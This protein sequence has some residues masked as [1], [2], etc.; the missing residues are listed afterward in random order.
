MQKLLLSLFVMSLFSCENNSQTN[1]KTDILIEENS[2]ISINE[3]KSL[4]EQ[5]WETFKKSVLDKNIQGIAAFASSD[6]IDSET[7]LTYLSD[8]EILKQLK[9]TS[10]NNLT[11]EIQGESNYLV[12]S[13]LLNEFDDDGNQYESGIYLYFIKSDTNLMLDYYLIAG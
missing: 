3:N 12:F 1:V 11:S 9:L 13:V 8:E 5:D 6:E 10:F 2:G 4:F 7:L